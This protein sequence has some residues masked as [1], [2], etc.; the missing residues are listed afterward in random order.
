V[1]SNGFGF[2]I[3]WAAH[4]LVTVEASS[5]LDH[6]IWVPVATNTL[7]GGSS[8]FSDPE[9]TNYPARFYRLRSL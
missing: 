4:V 6:P 5:A 1:Q 7:V 9:W 3:S 8:Y 2:V